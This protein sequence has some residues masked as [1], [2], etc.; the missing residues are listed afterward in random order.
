[1][2]SYKNIQTLLVT[3]SALLGSCNFWDKAH[4]KISS[5]QTDVHAT[6]AADSLSKPVWDPNKIQQIEIPSDSV[7][8]IS[9]KNILSQNKHAFE[10]GNTF[11]AILGK[12]DASD[13]VKIYNPELYASRDPWYNWA[14]H[15]IWQVDSLIVPNIAPSLKWFFPESLDDL[16]ATDPVLRDLV[17]D[18]ETVIIVRKK[19]DGVHFVSGQYIKKKIVFT[20]TCSVGKWDNAQA[21]FTYKD[22]KWTSHKEEYRKL[23]LLGKYPIIYKEKNHLTT[24]KHLLPYFQCTS[25]SR[26]TWMHTYESN[27]T[28]ESNSCNRVT[29]EYAHN[30]YTH[31]HSIQ[32]YKKDPYKKPTSIVYYRTPTEKEKEAAQRFFKKRGKREQFYSTWNYT[33][34]GTIDSFYAT[35][36]AYL[37]NLDPTTFEPIQP[38]WDTATAHLKDYIPHGKKEKTILNQSN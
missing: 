27:A 22:S 16:L 34:T 37:Y 3:A 15:S 36:F 7:Y 14:G 21:T 19:E 33:Q 11:G 30:T 17:W 38:K 28:M 26:G 20:G 4:E 31:T 29:L 35:K 25:S 32:D 18:D 13:I 5:T 6:L 9:A 1:M 23:T 8:T 2:L 10:T 24:E 12:Y